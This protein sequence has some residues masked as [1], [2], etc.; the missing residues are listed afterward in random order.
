MGEPSPIAG[1]TR[2]IMNAYHVESNRVNVAGMSAGRVMTVILAVT[3]PDLYAAVG[4]HSGL[5]YRDAHDVRPGFA[6]MRRGVG[7]SARRLTTVIPL[8]A[9][10][11]TAIR[12]SPRSTL[13]TCSTSGCGQRAMSRA[14][15]SLVSDVTN[16]IPASHIIAASSSRGSQIWNALPP[17]G[18]LSAQIRPWCN[19]TRC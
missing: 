13:I 6:A 18:Q 14:R 2:Q 19:A 1:I 7:R 3:Y 10:M 15:A 8:I 16:D 5:A 12:L 11:A 4:V 17:S 9:S